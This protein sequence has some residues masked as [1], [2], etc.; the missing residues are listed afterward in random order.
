MKT[1]LLVALL[2]LFAGCMRSGQINNCQKGVP[3]IIEYDSPRVGGKPVTL[4]CGDYR[5]QA[6]PGSATQTVVKLTDKMFFGT[7]AGKE[8]GAVVIAI[9]L[10][11]S[12]TFYDLALLR[13]GRLGWQTEDSVFLG[14]RIQVDAL[15]V[16]RDQ[17]VVRMITHGPDD[18]SCCPTREETKTFT[19]QHSPFLPGLAEFLS[20]DMSPVIGDIWHWKQTE[21]TDG[22]KLVSP[23]PEKY[24]LRLMASGEF[25][26][27][28]DCNGKGGSYTLQGGQLSL[29][30]IRSTT[31]LCEESSLEESYTQALSEISHVFLRED[32]LYFELINNSGVM[33]FSRP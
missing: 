29:K 2:V 23:D 9:D 10:G 26:A 31:A 16:Q 7:L 13:P 6:A 20:S 30:I 17:M 22:P 14:D 24:T 12:G 21:L 8:L 3:K 19:V 18:P 32:R 11:G 1:T 15:N 28:A 33:Q 4:Q 25:K 27:Q 5:A